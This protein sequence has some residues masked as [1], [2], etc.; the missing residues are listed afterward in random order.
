MKRFEVIHEL[1]D[2]FRNRYFRQIA[3][4]FIPNQSHR[5]YVVQRRG[6]QMWILAD[7]QLEARGEILIGGLVIHKSVSTPVAKGKTQTSQCA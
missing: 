2:E 3:M 6:D 5:E 1:V 4:R 7:Q